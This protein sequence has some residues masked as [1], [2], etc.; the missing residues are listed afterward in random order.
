MYK[1][2]VAFYF[3][4]LNAKQ[5]QSMLTYIR[6]PALEYYL[7]NATTEPLKKLIS[8]DMRLSYKQ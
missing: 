4:I 1:N 7:Q 5:L 8:N 6:G 2:E 3:W